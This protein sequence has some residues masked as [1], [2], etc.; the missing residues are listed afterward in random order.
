MQAIRGDRNRVLAG[1]IVRAA[2]RTDDRGEI[3]GGDA[4]PVR[5]CVILSL[6]N[7]GVEGHAETV[8]AH[9]KQQS[10]PRL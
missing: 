6:G 7:R 5:H 3:G 8:C 2:E 4:R 9:R 1:G 10:S